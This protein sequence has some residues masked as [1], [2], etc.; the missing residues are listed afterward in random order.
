MDERLKQLL[1]DFNNK[2]VEAQHAREKV[3]DYLEVEY[4]IDTNAEC[5]TLEDECDW[6]YGIDLKGLTNLITK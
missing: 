3:M 1:L 2:L 5:E 6:C 4:D